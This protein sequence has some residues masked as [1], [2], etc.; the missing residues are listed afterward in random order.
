[1]PS[2]AIL[3]RQL[4]ELSPADDILVVCGAPLAHGPI[5]ERLARELEALPSHNP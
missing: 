1:M 2:A 5:D 3:R 4:N